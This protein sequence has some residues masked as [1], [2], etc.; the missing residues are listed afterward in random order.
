[1]IWIAPVAL[2]VKVVDPPERITR[3]AAAIDIVKGALLDFT[4]PTQPLRKARLAITIVIR[5]T[6]TVDRVRIPAILRPCKI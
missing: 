5:Q 2:I 3:G 6:N 4:N 1:M